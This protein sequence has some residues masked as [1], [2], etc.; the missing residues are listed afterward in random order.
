MHET[1]VELVDDTPAAAQSPSLRQFLTEVMET[2]E[3]NN[4]GLYDF[5]DTLKVVL[6]KI[7]L[8]MGYN[9]IA[10]QDFTKVTPVN[11]GL[12]SPQVKGL[13]KRFGILYGSGIDPEVTTLFVSQA[14]LEATKLTVKELLSISKS[15]AILSFTAGEERLWSDPCISY[16]SARS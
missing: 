13:V 7:M 6:L 8:E 1:G 9:Y 14:A 3:G 2:P 5:I 16:D 11:Q 10:Y 4:M 12:V 15:S